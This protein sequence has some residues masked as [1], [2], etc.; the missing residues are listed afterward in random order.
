MKVYIIGALKNKAIPELANTL[1]D[2]GFEVFC[3]WFSPGP[4]CDQC[5]WEYGKTRGWDYKRTLKSEAAQL[6]YT[7]DIDH[8]NACD[9]GVMLMPCGKSGHAELGYLIGRGTP[10]YILFDAPP[11]RLDLMPAN[12]ATDIFFDTAALIAA[13]NTTLRRP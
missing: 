5:L 2:E 9:V 3:D 7:F 12:L 11:E 4:E 13:L 8:L 10:A 6:A 1:E